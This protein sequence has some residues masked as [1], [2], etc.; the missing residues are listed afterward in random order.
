MRDCSCSRPRASRSARWPGWLA[1]RSISRSTPRS[2]FAQACST[3]RMVRRQSAGSRR[4]CSPP[5]RHSSRAGSSGATHRKL[6]VA[7]CSAWRRLS[8]AT[9][10]RCAPP[11]FRSNSSAACWHSGRA[12]RSAAKGR[13]CRW[14][15]RSAI[16]VGVCSSS[17]PA[18]PGCCWLP[19]RARASLP[20][21]TR[22]SRA[23]SSCSRSSC[24]VSSCASPWR[25]LR[26]AARR[27]P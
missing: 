5:R 12:W 17:A 13:R 26:H 19:A 6:Q 20:H 27:W 21:S 3:G 22:R 23:R 16:C 2:V 25:R 15:P 14:G 18:M 1:P 10:S 4:Y 11:C 7:A 24:G 8:A 9:L